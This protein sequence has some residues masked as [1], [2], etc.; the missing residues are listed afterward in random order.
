MFNKKHILLFITLFSL[1]CQIAFSATEYGIFDHYTTKDGL[2]SNRVFSIDQDS[3]GFIWLGTDFGLDRFDG[4]SFIHH[5]KNNY[6]SLDR[7]GFLFIHALP[8]GRITGGGYYGFFVEYDPVKDIFRSVMPEEYNETFYKE[9]MEVYIKNGK[10]YAYSSCGAYTYDPKTESYSSENHL[11]RATRNLFVRA[12]HIDQKKRYW[13]GSMDS[14]MVFS[15]AGKLQLRYKPEGDACS[16]VRTML[17]L[18][19]SLLLVASQ[20][21]E[22]WIFNT[23]QTDIQPPRV[24]KTPFDCITNIICDRQGRYW[25]ATDAHGLWYTDD[26]LCADPQFTNLRPFNASIDDAQKIYCIKED[27][28][29]DIWFGTQ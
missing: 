17:P 7:E 29:G 13:L 4:E 24:I 25:I 19:D 27:D 16:F 26:F 21:A 9:T 23:N 2:I 1:A 14:M 28:K 6:S 5:R 15:A 10:Q 18:N 20:T 3:N 12:M 11:F 22:V 8:N